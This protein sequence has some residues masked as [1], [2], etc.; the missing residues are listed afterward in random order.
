LKGL[1]NR[2]RCDL[3]N[4]GAESHQ[5]EARHNQ[6]MKLT[7]AFGARSLS[8]RRWGAGKASQRF[9]LEPM[10]TQGFPTVVPFR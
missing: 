5:S 2:K 6:P 1:A 4:D 8:V 3:A 7:V 9:P 10:T